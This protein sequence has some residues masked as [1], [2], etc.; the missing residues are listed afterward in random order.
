M[1]LHAS[2]V[3]NDIPHALNLLMLCSV[4]AFYYVQCELFWQILEMLNKKKLDVS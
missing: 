2:S 1:E 3:E 4:N